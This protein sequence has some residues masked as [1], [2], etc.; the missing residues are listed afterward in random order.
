MK[1]KLSL[2]SIGDLQQIFST[3]Y[4]LKQSYKNHNENVFFSVAE[5]RLQDLGNFLKKYCGED[6]TL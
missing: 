4:E 6:E 3:V 2:V 5:R 1:E